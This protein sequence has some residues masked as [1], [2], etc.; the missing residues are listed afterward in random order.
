MK[1]AVQRIQEHFDIP[2]VIDTANPESLT[3]ALE[4]A[5]HPILVNSVNGEEKRLT[6]F[7]PVI[8]GTDCAVIALAMDDSGIPQSAE[9]RL[10]VAEKVVNE[11]VKH[12]FPEEQ[13]IV[14]PLCLTVA[15]DTSQALITLKALRLVEEKL[16]LN[17]V[18]GASNVSFGL[19]ARTLVNSAFLAMALFAGLDA[20]ITDPLKKEISAT[21][22]AS[23]LLLGKDEFAMDFI[24]WY[25]SQEEA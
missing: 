21:L 22:M 25:R 7:L 19:P 12:N 23:K 8:S 3:A 4:V 20:V 17:T 10:A 15:S 2:L 11:L 1:K 18:L 16:G 24:S 14:D 13:I 6:E 9:G 5:K